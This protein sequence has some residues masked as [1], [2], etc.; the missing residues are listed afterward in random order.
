MGNDSGNP[1]DPINS[2]SGELIRTVASCDI[3]QTVET[4]DI[5]K[6]VKLSVADIAIQSAKKLSCDSQTRLFDSRTQNSPQPSDLGE[7]EPIPDGAVEVMSIAT[8]PNGTS[9]TIFLDVAKRAIEARPRK[10]GTVDRNRLVDAGMCIEEAYAGPFFK[11]EERINEAK[12]IIARLDGPSEV[13]GPQPSDLTCTMAYS[14]SELAAIDEQ[15]RETDRKFKES[16]C[17]DDFN[18][19]LIARGEEPIESLYPE[20]KKDS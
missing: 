16:G 15:C 14:T 12:D 3:R 8:N 2:T 17:L 9:E 7:H 6:K 19:Y 20:L 4:K 1:K 13:A 18:K 11:I 10:I 5:S